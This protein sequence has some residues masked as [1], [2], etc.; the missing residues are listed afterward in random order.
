M[1]SPLPNDPQPP[2]RRL[3]EDSDLKAAQELF[4]GHEKLD[5]KL[6]EFSPKTAKDFEILGRVLASTYVIPHAS[7]QHYKGL[8]KALVK[9]VLA[10][11]DTQ[12]VKDV[13]TTLAGLRTEK[14]KEER[15][16]ATA[17]KGV[18]CLPWLCVAAGVCRTG[19]QPAVVTD[20]GLSCDLYSA[21]RCMASVQCVQYLNACASWAGAGK[22]KTLNAG[23]SGGS[24]G[25][26]DY[27]F[28]TALDDDT[29]F[30]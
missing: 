17:A 14:L 2:C 25:L 1:H 5:V 7:S 29:D 11:S 10:P 26:E 4:G 6:D 16:K 9:A 13:E 19:Y 8:L 3:I 28:D 22:K 27:H 18:A 30:M 24:A 15:A 21:P 20:L 12:F 23:R